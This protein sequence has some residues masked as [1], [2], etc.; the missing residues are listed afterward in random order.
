MKKLSFLVLVA[1]CGPRP[2]AQDTH[3][4]S[5]SSEPGAD[6]PTPVEPPGSDVGDDDNAGGDDDSS[7]ASLDQASQTILD[8][9]NKDR[10]AHCAPPLTW[11]DELAAVAQK[12]ADHLRD[13]GCGFEHS[14]TEYGENLAGGT[15]GA[16]P[17]E[18]VVSMWYDEKKD[19]NF[20]HG[21]F[22]MDTGHFTQLVWVGT[23]QMGCGMSQCNGMDLWVCNYDPAGNVDGEYRDNVKPT[24]CR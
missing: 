14:S 19:F 21:G 16:L 2:M 23:T 10:A 22:G 12:W 7:G 15:T 24:S 5:G 13:E 3:A 4:A 18:G 1:A 17:P 8:E 6:D 9:T 20:K 11:S